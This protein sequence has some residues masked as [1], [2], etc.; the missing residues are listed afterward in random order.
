MGKRISNGTPHQGHYDTRVGLWDFTK[1]YIIDN[2]ITPKSLQLKKLLDDEISM[3]G[4][5]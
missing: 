3:T 4:K 1:K 2:K 5:R